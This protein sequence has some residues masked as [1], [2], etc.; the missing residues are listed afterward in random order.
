MNVKKR[1]LSPVA[2]S[3]LVAAVLLVVLAIGM[4]TVVLPQKNTA[5]SVAKE[6]ALSPRRQRC[7][8]PGHDQ[9]LHSVIGGATVRVRQ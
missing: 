7:R 8:Q 5:A 9:S 1:K 3:A 2:A 4:F 6:I